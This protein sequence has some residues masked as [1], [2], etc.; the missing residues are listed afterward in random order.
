MPQVSAKFCLRCELY[1]QIIQSAIQFLNRCRVAVTHLLQEFDTSVYKLNC[2]L[3]K[4]VEVPE[5][6]PEEEM[7][8]DVPA[9][10]DQVGDGKLSD[11]TGEVQNEKL[12]GV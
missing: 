11:Q 5:P 6:V 4:T 1:T 7:T 8:N 12:A 3:L 10:S 2:N 9:G